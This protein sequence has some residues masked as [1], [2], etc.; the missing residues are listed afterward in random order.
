MPAITRNG[1][2]R[3][4][5]ASAKTS[6]GDLPPSSS[7]TGTAFRA[8]AAWTSAPV[9]TEPV[10]GN[11]VDAGMAGQRRTGLLAGPG[12]KVERAGRQSRIL[13]NAGILDH[14]EA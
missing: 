10:K 5:S 14:C 11:V 1:K 7:V 6:W 13:R 2:A 4:R 9:V 12:D 3:S 8:A